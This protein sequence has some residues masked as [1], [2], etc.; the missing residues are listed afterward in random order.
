MYNT[1]NNLFAS[2]R[3]LLSTR[4]EQQKQTVVPHIATI[5][6]LYYSPDYTSERSDILN[7]SLEFYDGRNDLLRESFAAI[8]K[9]LQ[10]TLK[11]K[12]MDLR[13]ASNVFAFY[14]LNNDLLVQDRVE[15]KLL[16]PLVLQMEESIITTFHK[17]KKVFGRNNFLSLPVV[18]KPSNLLTPREK[19]V[20][21]LVAQGLMNK[22]IADQLNIG[23]TTVISHRKHIV[24][25]LGIK[26]IPGLT[27]YAYT[28][29]YINDTLL[30]NED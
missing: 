23:L 17:K 30:T 4:L 9:L 8:R 20:L 3:L 18:A 10:K 11:S 19:E 28:H 15:Q 1:L 2:F 13:Y 21:R 25:K 22:E 29:G 7:Y 27:V 14:Q 12:L 24:E 6:E 26:T 16:R 5:Y